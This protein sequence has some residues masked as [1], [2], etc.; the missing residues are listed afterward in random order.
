MIRRS[1]RSQCGT[2]WGA[3]FGT[4]H[5]SPVTGHQPVTRGHHCATSIYC[6]SLSFRVT[7]QPSYRTK[8]KIYFNGS[9]SN[10]VQNT[11]REFGNCPNREPEPVVRFGSTPEPEP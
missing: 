11:F 3:G 1:A 5:M 6:H 4:R 7:E 8:K 10:A 2:C 9:G